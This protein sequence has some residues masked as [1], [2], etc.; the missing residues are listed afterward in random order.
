M[1]LIVHWK[2]HARVHD[3][4]CI[5]HIHKAIIQYA[6]IIVIKCYIYMQD[7]HRLVKLDERL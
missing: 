3:L 6:C 4:I 1:E 7:Y 5:V 2:L